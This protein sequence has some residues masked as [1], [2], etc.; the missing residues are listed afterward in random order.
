M[1]EEREDEDH[2]GRVSLPI[3]GSS[4]N[5]ECNDAM[6]VKSQNTYGSPVYLSTTCLGGW[7][8]HDIADSAQIKYCSTY[9]VVSQS[10][11]GMTSQLFSS[12]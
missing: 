7:G 6:Q 2:P 1:R 3:L 4:S 11:T 10:F 12:I 5:L 9:Q 8:G